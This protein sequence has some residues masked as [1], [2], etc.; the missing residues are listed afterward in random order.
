MHRSSSKCLPSQAREIGVAEWQG[1]AAGQGQEQR[2]RSRRRTKAGK[3]KSKP[4]PRGQ[5]RPARRLERST[6]RACARP[7]VRA[8]RPGRLLRR[9]Q[10]RRPEAEGLSRPGDC[11]VSG[12]HASVGGAGVSAH[13]DPVRVREA[14]SG[15][16]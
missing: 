9:H 1:I 15:N 13:S 10:A 14:S 12:S 7:C 8:T 5:R 16:R 4:Y 3:W 11:L 2:A 6:A